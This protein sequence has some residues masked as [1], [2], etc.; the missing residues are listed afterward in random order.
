M[1]SWDSVVAPSGYVGTNLAPVEPT[2]ME[3]PTRQTYNTSLILCIL[4]FGTYI[5]IE[6]EQNSKI[7]N[8]ET[9]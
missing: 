3:T 2:A 7:M 9:K 8:Q 5:C 6:R 1:A 4:V